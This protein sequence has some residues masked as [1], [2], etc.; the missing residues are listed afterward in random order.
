MTRRTRPRSAPEEDRMTTRSTPAVVVGVDGTPG[1]YGALRYAAVEAD[2]RGAPLR[3]VHAIPDAL[4]LGPPVALTDFQDAG[5][6]VVA[7]ALQTAR[8][9]GPDLEIDTL[10]LSGE[11]SDTIV[12]AARD[13]QLLVVGRETRSGLDRLLTGT[14]TA[15]AAAH[16]P[17]SAVVVPSWWVGD[18]SHGRVVVGVKSAHDAEELVEEAL[19]EA[20]AREASLTAV[21]AWHIA[22]PY[23]DRIE[24]R[25]HEA[26]WV[27]NGTEELER[28][29]APARER[30][31]EVP[32]EVH[33]VHG[34]PA[35]VL[36]DASEHSDLLLV[37]RRRFALPPYGRLGGVGH[38]LLRLSEVPVQVVPY[39]HTVAEGDRLVL[40]EAGAP[41]K[42]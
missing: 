27:A 11:R 21:M 19:A 26:D 15:A 3:L 31:P 28:L 42:Q 29:L 9:L 23:L 33:V 24:V 34:Q 41:L 25:T 13:A 16:A 37:S 2:R 6:A 35:R 7:H 5:R 36:L 32:V 17:C 8:D 40:E 1:S 4:T 12:S 18:R 14:T 20:A 30:F 10:L 22:D 39:A 38:S